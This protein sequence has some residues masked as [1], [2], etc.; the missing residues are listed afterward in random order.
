MGGIEN[1]RSRAGGQRAL[2]RKGHFCLFSLVRAFDRRIFFP[3]LSAPRP[4]HAPPPLAL[5][6]LFF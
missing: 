3:F 4:R 2:A 6:S 5:F 1:L